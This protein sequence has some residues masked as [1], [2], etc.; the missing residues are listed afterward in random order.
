MVL[1]LM[2]SGLITGGVSRAERA[3]PFRIG[4]LTT[5]WGPTPHVVALR[6]ALIE[7]GYQENQDFVI[8][9]RFTQ[10]DLTIVPD[11]ARDLVRQGADL[12]FVIEAEPTRLVQQ[13]TT[14]IPIVFAWV[15]DPVGQGLVQSFARPGGNTTGVTNLTHELGPKRLE[16]FRELIPSLKRVLYLYDIKDSPSVTMAQV[17]RKAARHLGLVLIEKPVRTEAEAQAT[18]AQVRKG[19]VDGMLRPPSVSFNIPGLVADAALK[20][21][22]PTMFESGFFVERGVLAGYGPNSFEAGRQVA[23]LVDK[24]IK[25]QNPGEIPVEVNSTIKFTINLKTAKALG[26]TIAPEVMFQATKL[27]R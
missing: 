7:L 1:L 5:S 24:I 6:D 21:S 18:L 16:L 25:G 9:V 19:E 13:V 12:I 8:G 11:A 26:L 22:I 27:I 17:Y 10:G 2:S 23:R 20:Q 4:A 15:G 14:Q 3:R